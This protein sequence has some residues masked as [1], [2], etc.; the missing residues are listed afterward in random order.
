[1][2]LSLLSHEEQALRLIAENAVGDLLKQDGLASAWRGNEEAPLPLSNGSK[3]VDYAH[4]E[5][6]PACFQEQPLHTSKS[7]SGKDMLFVPE[8]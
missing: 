3:P 1:M 8:G 7:L 5:V 2:A 6:L 4:I